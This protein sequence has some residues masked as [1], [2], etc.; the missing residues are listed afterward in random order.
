M[1]E[2]EN[3]TNLLIG[4]MENKMLPNAK[5]N[6]HPIQLPQP[7]HSQITIDRAFLNVIHLNNLR[8]I[9]MTDLKEHLLGL[10]DNR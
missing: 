3:V 9:I 1:K 4:G 7:Q 2:K 8:S 10:F 6:S 5:L